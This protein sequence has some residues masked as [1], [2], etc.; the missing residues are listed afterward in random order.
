MPSDTF[1]LQIFDTGISIP[2]LHATT[3]LTGGADAIPTAVASVAGVGGSAGLMSALQAQQLVTNNGKV[4]NA[5]HDGDV[6]GATTL[7]IGAGKVTTAKILDLNVTT[8][9]IAAAAVDQYK[10][11]DGNVTLAKLANVTGPVVLGRSDSSLGGVS[12][13]SCTALGFDLISKATAELMRSTLGL[14]ALA[15]EDALTVNLAADVGTSVLPVANGGTGVTTST[16]TGAVVRAVSPT[17]STPTLSSATLTSPTLSS[18]TLTAPTFSGAILG[19]PTSGVLTNCTGLPLTTGVAGVLPIVKGGTGFTSAARGDIYLA[20]GSSIIATI[21][22]TYYVIP[23]SGALDGSLNLNMVAGTTGSFSIKNTSGSTRV[24]AIHASVD[25]FT[26]HTNESIGLRLYSGVSGSLSQVSGAEVRTVSTSISLATSL[27]LSKLVSVPD[28]S[29]VAI[30]L[31]NHSAPA[32]NITVQR[33]GLTA[34]A[35]I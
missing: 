2:A 5:D 17:L 25:A 10:I 4:T 23:A 24:F 30:Y 22:D 29:E 28:G 16:G 3:H 8:A 20:A 21:I 35:L 34:V 14:G 27:S 15:I 19:T 26:T 7:T 31:A 13:I 9:K 11:A 32:H 12:A 18:A 33:A 1:N 6:S